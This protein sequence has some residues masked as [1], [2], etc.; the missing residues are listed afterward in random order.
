MRGSGVV[1]KNPSLVLYNLAV[2]I[3]SVIAL[4]LLVL[5]YYFDSKDMKLIR[6][7]IPKKYITMYFVAGMLLAFTIVV[8]I[9]YF[10]FTQRIIISLIDDK[11]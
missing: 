9:I 3:C 4:F 8:S 2:M 10:T 6:T 5:F 1:Y 7:H 11:K